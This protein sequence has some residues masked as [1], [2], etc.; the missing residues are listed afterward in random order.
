M[1]LKENHFSLCFTGEVGKS[2]R[3][4]PS[5]RHPCCF[6]WILSILPKP[7]TGLEL[8]GNC[9]LSIYKIWVGSSNLK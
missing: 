8:S 9:V 7:Q 3:T 1:R 6:T 2:R 5:P 4:F